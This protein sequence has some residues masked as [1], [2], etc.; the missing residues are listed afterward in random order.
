MSISCSKTSLIDSLQHL[1][2]KLSSAGQ[3]L[4]GDL[5]Q[6]S[7]VVALE[8]KRNRRLGDRRAG[9]GPAAI[10]ARPHPVQSR[11][12]SAALLRDGLDRRY[13]VAV[14]PIRKSGVMAGQSKG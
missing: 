5:P 10:V 14:K 12:V 13:G 1:V 4:L 11:H 2:T 8:A 9:Q 7:P 6:V 3:E